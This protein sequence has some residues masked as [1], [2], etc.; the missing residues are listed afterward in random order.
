M[1][2]ADTVFGYEELT[3]PITCGSHPVR[4]TTSESPFLVTVARSLMFSMPW[5]SS[6]RTDSPR[7]TPSFHCRMHARLWRS[8][9]SRT[10][11]TAAVVVAEG[12]RVVELQR[13]DADALLPD[14]RRARIVGAVGR[15]ADIALMRAVDGPE[16]E[17]LAHEHGKEDGQVGQ[18]IAPVIGIVEQV[19][20]ARA[21]A[22][23]EVFRHRLDGQR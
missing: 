21:D 10:S 1:C 22:S 9:L 2:T 19:H 6:S 15:S 8:A 18:V 4:S 5:P 20:V 11:P 23:R 7:Y 3:K 17:P 13:R 16:G 12:A 14:L